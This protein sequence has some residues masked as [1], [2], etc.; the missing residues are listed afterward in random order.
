MLVVFPYHNHYFPFLL[1]GRDGLFKFGNVLEVIWGRN[2]SPKITVLCTSFSAYMDYQ[3][4]FFAN[5]PAT[6]FLANAA[7]NCI[8]CLVFW[9]F[10]KTI[11]KMYNC[12]SLAHELTLGWWCTAKRNTFYM[13]AFC[14]TNSL[15][16]SCLPQKQ[17]ECSIQYSTMFYEKNF[18][19]DFF[20]I[21]KLLPVTLI[22]ISHLTL[23][24]YVIICKCIIW[25][26]L[27]FLI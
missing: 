8:I 26:K 5:L 21:L 14:T 10:T 22:L 19:C 16:C 20:P 6:T 17:R 15:C 12:F 11:L 25:Q 2:Y 18:N 9:P 24:Y 23:H 4:N 3:I 7:L 1:V 27:Y 13:R